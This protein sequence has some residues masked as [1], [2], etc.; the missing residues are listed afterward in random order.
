MARSS[1]KVWP[2]YSM[3]RTPSPASIRPSFRRVE[4]VSLPDFPSSNSPMASSSLTSLNSWTEEAAVVEGGDAHEEA[5][6][7]GGAFTLGM[8]RMAGEGEGEEE[9][10]DASP[11]MLTSSL[12]SVSQQ[13][14][15]PLIHLV[16]FT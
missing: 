12:S 14:H 4:S 1:L 2:R 10:V 13:P 15:N 9:G 5:F 16:I 8:F 11:D 6:P 7:D 3:E